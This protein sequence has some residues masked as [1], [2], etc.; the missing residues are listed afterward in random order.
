MKIKNKLSN[1][2]LK[3]KLMYSFLIIIIAIMLP[4]SFFVI[5][6]LQ[7]NN[8]YQSMVDNMA[9]EGNIKELSA[10]LIIQTNKLV[11]NYNEND[12]K[13]Y[14]DTWEQ[15]SILLS[16][17]DQTIIYPQSK[18]LYEGV[19]NT[20]K[21]TK[22]DSNMAILTIKN[23]ANKSKATDYYNSASKKSQ[24][25][26]NLSGELV[27]TELIYLDQLKVE[28]QHSYMQSLA[29]LGGFA[30]IAIAIGLSF[31]LSLANSITKNVQKL[32]KVAA[33]I[34]NG[35][36]S[37]NTD[38]VFE[39]SK[40]E[41]TSLLYTFHQMKVSLNSV[42]KDVMSGSNLVSSSSSD[43]A[44]SME[45]SK[46][47]NNM[48]IASVTSVCDVVNQQTEF[49][50]SVSNK[51]DCVNGQ[52]SDTL[53]NASS[54]EENIK[55]SKDTIIKGNTTIDT[56]NNQIQTINETIK[57]FK[58]RADVL[59]DYSNSIDSIVQ[60]INGISEQTNLLSLNASIEAA[61]AGEAGKGFSVVAGEIRKLSEQT[62]LATS[63][64]KK[65][66]DDIKLNAMKINEEAIVGL[67]EINENSNLA[68]E[69][70]NVL[71]EI[72]KANICVTGSSQIIIKNI[73]EVSKEIYAI[74]KQVISLNENSR[75]LT[76]SSESTSSITQE[77]L[78]I[79]DEVTNQSVLL[80]G[81]ATKLH[82]TV[83]KF[84]L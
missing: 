56:M 77:Q 59:T 35:D 53:S 51:I 67:N 15:L 16:K 24:F 27:N 9:N 49:V 32:T 47:A 13:E 10:K 55:N 65:M 33:E 62:K 82:A 71:S 4:T 80:Q 34:S 69:A 18:Q 75:I 44:T 30:L 28:I 54:L 5:K 17:L 68:K 12:L 64:I 1:T 38:V 40:D 70:I 78:A 21:N 31:S 76:D 2:S 72:N 25:I 6:S 36:L 29:F 8:Q 46:S 41:I 73:E 39:K 50:D 81:M 84:K 45:Q 66:I 22:I 48:I 79:S 52:L 63:D 37:I 74:A 26:N 14:N 43:L 61:R 3:S 60:V 42:M 19:K 20:V 7:L 57:R 83:E 23:G 11:V 58:G